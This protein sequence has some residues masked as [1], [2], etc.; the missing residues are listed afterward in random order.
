MRARPPGA[1]SLAAAVALAGAVVGLGAQV[2]PLSVTARLVTPVSTTTSRVGDAVRAVVVGLPGGHS[3]IP[4]GCMVTGRVTGAGHRERGRD[5]RAVLRLRFDG[6][7]D[8]AGAAH[9]A[10]MQITA[11]DN[12]RES[13]DDDGAIVGLAPVRARPRTIET[14]LMLASHAH[15]M[16]LAAAEALR[17]GVKV[18]VRQEIAFQPGVDLTMAVPPDANLGTLICAGPATTDAPPDAVV[19]AW[20]LTLPLRTQAGTPPRDADWI[21]LAAL[22]SRDD[23]AAAF[24][25]AGWTTADNLSVRAD[26]RTFFA[27]VEREG[28]LTGPFSRLSLDGAGPAMVFQKQ[29]NTFAKRHHV[30]FWPAPGVAPGAQEAW[31]AAA[32]HDI[33]LEFSHETRH[34]THRIDGAIDDERRAL[35]TD[36]VA[37]GALASYGF[38]A[39]P[40]VPRQSTNA[41]GDHVTTDGQLAVMAFGHAPADHAMARR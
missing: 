24:A 17:L 1:T 15:P 4:L 6:V 8:A 12:A 28:Y 16:V 33:G 26:V 23:I 41:T 25:Q 30:R 37:T 35:V 19:A 2:A 36:L 18:A 21:N 9:P 20:A 31:V 32:T 27:V 10:G 39:R 29:T 22:G 40:A 13:I 14:I 11:V 34:Y 5:G 38:V 3:P 7:L